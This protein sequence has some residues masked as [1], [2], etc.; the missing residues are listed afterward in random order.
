[1]RAILWIILIIFTLILPKDGLAVTIAS[2]TEMFSDQLNA[3]QI[4]QELGTNLT[5]TFESFTFRVSAA[6]S[7]LSQFDHTTNNS[8]LYDKTTNKYIVS[9]SPP[10]DNG[11]FKG[12]TFNTG[13]VPAGYEDVT[14]DFSCHNYN[15][16]PGHRYLIKISNANIGSTILF[17]AALSSGNTDYFPDGGVRYANSNRYDYDNNSGSCNPLTYIWNGTNPYRNG[18]YVWGNA[19]SDIYFVLNN[20]SPPPPPPKLPVIFIPGI[21]GSE[22]KAS[23]QIFWKAP[24]GHGGEF[25]HGYGQDEKIWVNQDEATK[26]GDDDYFDVL[27]LKADGQTSA[28]DLSLTGNLTPFGYGEIDSFFESMGYVKGTNYF[29][30]PYDWRKD[31]RSNKDSLDSL[32][33]QAKTLSGQSKVNLVAHSMGGLLARYYISDSSKSSKINKL[34]ELGVPHLGAVEDIKAIVYGLPLGK[35]ILRFFNIGISGSEIKDIFQ[36]LSSAFQLLP[37]KHYFDFY[38]NSNTDQLYPFR[39][40]RDIDNNK[41][42][43]DLDFNQIKILLTNLDLNMAVFNLAEQLHDS[44]QSLFEKSNDVKLYS[45]VGSNQ[46]T[47]GQI[48]ETWWITWPINLI[49]KRDEIFVNGDGTVPL[50]S[51]SLK[52]NSKDFS[53]GATIYYTEQE[54]VDLVRKDGV[55]MQTVKSILNDDNALPAEVKSLKIDLEGQQLTLDDGELELYDGDKHTGIKDNGEI[56]E[57]IPDTSYTTSG[58]TK[59]AFVKKKAK[60][61]VVKTTRKKPITS[62][63]TTN[64]KIRTYAKDKISKTS[65]YKDIP[66]TE[67]G[68]AEFILD[69]STDTSPTLVFYADESKPDNTTIAAS[70]EVGEDAALDQIPP[71]TSIQISGTKDNSGI[72]TGPVT[73]ALIGNDSGS[74]ILK[75]EYSLDNGVTVQTYTE[76]F[77]ISAPGKTTIQVKSVDKSGNEE[78]PQ[79]MIIEIA[80]QPS[81]T[82]IPTPIPTPG[83]GSDSPGVSST[84]SSNSDSSNTPGV[85]F[86]S[87]GVSGVNGSVL[88]IQFEN[89]SHISDQINVSGILDELKNPTPSKITKTPAQQFLGGLLI[90]SGGIVT[91]ASAG[92]AATFLAKPI[93]K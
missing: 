2:Q 45:I 23:Q 78:I 4:I 19:K 82:P 86:D 42:T 48:R 16:I 29:I 88:G 1:M 64:L 74:G 73:I 28:A 63:K 49:P 36:N 20:N 77:T 11:R 24:D 65:L 33:E 93:P 80:S 58:K 43:G 67:M 15:F 90:V 14:L 12:L 41:I 9:C 34:I 66:L 50:Y 32:I 31:V 13:G 76:P 51:A 81:P 85:G 84:S 56:E 26:L 55:A 3:F 68:K 59:H 57:N 8:K 5:G 17:A 37:S 38:D 21:G 10:G 25:N 71:A 92:L 69:P 89:P 54:H 83:V 46:P 61:V 70:A 35:P 79:T 52:S 39:D 60:K 44:T 62:V 7:N 30:F 47:L 72:Y 18:C 22:L 91:L 27:R 40:E 87:P 6:K 53:A 75:I